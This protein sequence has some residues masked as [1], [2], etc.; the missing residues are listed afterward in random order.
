M[1]LPGR[2]PP[3]WHHSRL[4][5]D[6]TPQGAL[7]S[8]ESVLL[9][10]NL[11]E[12]LRVATESARLRVWMQEQE[13]ILPGV[14]EEG[15]SGPRVAF[16]LTMPEQPGLVWYYFFL[17]V[18]GRRRYY[19]GSSGI[20]APSDNP[21]E[22]YQITVYD[23]EFRTPEWFRKS[24]VYQIFPDRFRRDGQR[25]GLDRVSEHVKV[26]RK[27][28][29][30]EDWDES[31]LYRPLPAESEYAP[32]DYFGGTLEGIREGLAYLK[33]LG[34]GAIYLNPIFEAASN[35]R[36]NTT[37]YR[38]IDPVLGTEEDL[39][40]PCTRGELTRYPID[41]RRRIFPHR[42]TTASISTDM[43]ATAGRVR[44]FPKA[45]RISAGTR[46]YIGRI[47]T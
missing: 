27:A 25:G 36:Y 3:F 37:D 18:D 38:R 44:M 17:D 20:G 9:Y 40:R 39:L 8:G 35:H 32:C 26:G 19:G 42:W 22:S 23:G 7:K 24:I 30:Q 41:T 16:T 15:E 11:D 46:F 1:F 5:S 29:A 43:T 4:L 47:V 6:R 21:P 34:V 33:S 45:R 31:P 2:R 12:N 10:L 28:I 14:I 13:L